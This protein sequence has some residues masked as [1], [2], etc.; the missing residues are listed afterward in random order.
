MNRKGD[1]AWDEIGKWALVLL[2]ILILLYIIFKVK[3][4]TGGLWE[5][6]KNIFRFG[7]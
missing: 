4:T 6:I 1:I 5:N 2:L 7:A 3:N